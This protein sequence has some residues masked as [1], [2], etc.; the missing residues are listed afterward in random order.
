MYKKAILI[1]IGLSVIFA[2]SGCKL[3][4][5]DNSPYPD[6]GRDTV[7]QFGDRRFMVLRGEAE[8][9]SKV[10]EWTL[11]DNKTNDSID[12]SI[13][14]FKE[15]KPYVYTIGSE[16]YTK[17]NYETGQLKQSKTLSDF[18]VDDQKIFDMLEK[19]KGSVVKR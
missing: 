4:K 8:P 16:G 12:N 9:Y 13:D 18:S 7:A 6:G 14:N 1:F 15:V 10:I 11:Y 17:L 2:F 3:F 19:A 5:T